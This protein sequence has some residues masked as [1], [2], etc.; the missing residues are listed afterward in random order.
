MEFNSGETA[1]DLVERERSAIQQQGVKTV[2][3]H[4]VKSTCKLSPTNSNV[5]PRPCRYPVYSIVW[6]LALLLYLLKKI[7]CY[8]F[9]LFSNYSQ[10][11]APLGAILICIPVGEQSCSPL[12][13]ENFHDEI[14]FVYSFESCCVG[15]YGFG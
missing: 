3:L 15:V 2:M 10:P 11:E 13:V 5:S 1:I 7:G 14:N 6:Y 4:V 8:Y 12:N 9:L